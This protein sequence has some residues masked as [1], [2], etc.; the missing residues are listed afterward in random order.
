MAREIGRIGRVTMAE[1]AQEMME[2]DEPF[3]SED[4][5]RRLAQAEKTQ[6]FLRCY[7]G[8]DHPAVQ[9]LDHELAQVRRDVEQ[10][11]TGGRGE[12]G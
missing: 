5:M 6:D 1:D 11:G 3:P 10:A 9:R 7:L 4:L 12:D 2:D 8:G